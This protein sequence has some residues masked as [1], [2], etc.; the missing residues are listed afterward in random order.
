[1]T[2]ALADPASVDGLLAYL[3]TVLTRVPV[4]S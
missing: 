1:V 2:T 3:D 4:L